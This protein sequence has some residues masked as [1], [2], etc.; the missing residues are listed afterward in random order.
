MQQHLISDWLIHCADPVG[1]CGEPPRRPLA[2]VQ[3][4]EFVER[5]EYHGILAAVF[6]NFGPFAGPAE[7]GDDS[8]FAEARRDARERHRVQ[9]AFALMLQTQA[10]AVMAEANGIPAAIIKG[11]AFA[12]RIYPAPWYRPFTDID[13]LVAPEG[14]ERLEA[15]LLDHGFRSYGEH[16]TGQCRPWVHDA[17]D[18]TLFELHL[19]LNT[20]ENHKWHYVLT[21]DHIADAPEGPAAML[22]TAIGHGGAT[23]RFIRIQHVIDVCQAARHVTNAREEAAFESIVKKANARTLAVASLLLVGRILAEPR[24]FEL[25][26]GL[27]MN[28]LGQFAGRSLGRIAVA[29]PKHRFSAVTRLR[30]KLFREAIGFGDRARP[31]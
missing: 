23:H 27:G 20:G 11:P 17:F 5:A 9:R 29:G 31:L 30:Q 25:A 15:I 12:R 14:V 24:C 19:D 2:P 28:R 13:I 3:A 4:R 21:Y 7:F 26:A 6:Q 16:Q 18:P 10:D 1:P 8:S 22:M